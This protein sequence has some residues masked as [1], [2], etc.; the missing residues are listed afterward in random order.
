MKL[1]LVFLA[2]AFLSFFSSAQFPGCP[3]VDAGPDQ[4]LNCSIPCAT[5]TAIPFE[6]GSTT[7]YSVTSIPHNPPIA[8]NQPGTG[9]SIGTD[10]IWSPAITLPFNFC[11]Y[12][13]NYTQILVGS[14]GNLSFNVANSGGYCPWSYNATCPSTTLATLPAGNIFGVYHDIDPSVCGNI[15]WNLVGTSPC[16][17]FVVSF[18]QICQFSCT[19]ITSRH[20]MVLYE[21]T[22][23]IDVY[24]ESKP[25]CGGW[26]GGRALIGIQNPA[27][28]ADS[29]R[30]KHWSMDHFNT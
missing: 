24:V 5:L 26:N 10:D 7:S 16:R 14:N 6:A 20:M 15:K 1:S 12:G 13:V 27:G 3:N 30:K 25:T 22:N 4:T 21:T 2:T 8:Y 17:I 19:N 9:V 18:D 23:A 28:T 11:F 29:S